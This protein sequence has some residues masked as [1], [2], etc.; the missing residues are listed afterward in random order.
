MEQFLSVL[1]TMSLSAALVALVVMGI[2]FFFPKLPRALV[3]LLWLVVFFRMV[4]P[5]SFQLPVSLL[6]QGIADG[7]AAQFVL[8][9]KGAVFLPEELP[10]PD[11]ETGA[12]TAAPSAGEPAAP[13]AQPDAGLS[14]AGGLV[15][16]AP[17][18]WP[19]VVFGIWAGG[20]L[21]ALTWAGLCYRRFRRRTAEAV[22][23]AGNCY[24][25]DLIPS[26]FV[27]GVFR[28]KI[29]LPVGLAPRERH[30][31]LLHEEAHLRRKDN[32]A[33]PLAYVLLCF[34]W[35]NP[36]LWV[37]YRLLCLDIETA[38]DQAVL[39]QLDRGE[40]GSAADYAAALLHLSREAGI[41]SAVPL[42]FGE[43]DAKGRIAALLQYKRLA[44][45]FLAA[46]LAL[47]LVVTVC[48]AADPP[49]GTR[50]DGHP[51][52]QGAILDG[53]ETIP[54]PDDLFQALAALLEDT[55]RGPYT[56]C[57]DPGLPQGTLLLTAPG[58]SVEYRVITQGG[59]QPCL[60]QVRHGRQGDTYRAAPLKGE[61][62]GLYRDPLPIYQRWVGWWQAAD[63]LLTRPDP[64]AL[65]QLA[66]RSAEDLAAAQALLD[67]LGVR[68]TLGGYTLRLQTEANQWQTLVLA[69]ETPPASGSQR[70]WQDHVLKTQAALFLALVPEVDAVAWYHPDNGVG[71]RVDWGALP[72][73]EH[74]ENAR[75][76]FAY[77]YPQR[78]LWWWDA[79]SLPRFIS[80]SPSLTYVFHPAYTVEEVLYSAGEGEARPL[81]YPY[82][83][84]GEGYGEFVFSPLANQLLDESG[85]RPSGF[86]LQDAHPLPEDQWEACVPQGLLAGRQIRQAW[87]LTQ[88]YDPGSYNK[89]S[90]VEYQD[91]SLWS[92]SDTGYRLYDTDGGLYLALWQRE[93]A[94]GSWQPT[95]FLR[96]TEKAVSSNQDCRFSFSE[97]ADP[98]SPTIYDLEGD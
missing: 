27:L 92:E 22:K 86:T 93:G 82:M 28:P 30:Y 6:P 80:T 98:A 34:H 13:V 61:L 21:A 9:G 25:S 16:A 48:L 47:C 12:G 52:S 83:S 42:A 78:H 43:E 5:A 24:E 94:K 53:Q 72:D 33:K 60:V 17:P 19:R 35:F 70:L 87:Y 18:L 15:P 1:L 40:T 56:S 77:L 2:R 57:Q 91:H 75:S 89:T 71:F 38:C 73:G 96:L 69:Q 50:V 55:E 66:P 45:G 62:A 46:A 49:A 68:D 11:G 32:I 7:S 59:F 58:A 74:R 37:A 95:A 63:R 4:C 10:E 3:C 29:Y 31:V 23:V 54:L 14:S 36:V 90:L 76:A 88:R 8:D 97:D 64:S 26:P 67:G 39:R 20:T 41:P 65:A 81:G 84:V 51:V 85:F 79:L 44:P